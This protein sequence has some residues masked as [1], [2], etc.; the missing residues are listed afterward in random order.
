MTLRYVFVDESGNFD[1]SPRGSRYFTLTSVVLDT[2]NIGQELAQLR[3]EMV[4]QGIDLREGFHATE[5]RQVVRDEVFRLISTHDF[6]IDATIFEKSKVMPHLRPDDLEFYNTAFF[7]HMKYL[8]P[9][10]AGTGD[11]LL[12]VSATLSL[13]RKQRLAN[14][15]IADVVGAAAGSIPFQMAAWTAASEPCLQLTDYC[16]WAIQRKWERNDLRSYALIQQKIA[17]E[18]DIFRWGGKRYY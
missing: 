11:E 4:R 2:C 3:R 6:R 1:F 7:Y 13:K 17:S 18:F 10:V 14:E 8:L 5:D 12:I 9:R 15:A 16:S